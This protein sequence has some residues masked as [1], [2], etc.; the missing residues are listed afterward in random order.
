MRYMRL[1]LCALAAG[2]LSCQDD[3]SMGPSVPDDLV[4]RLEVSP[5]QGNLTAVGANQQ[6]SAV[7]RNAAGLALSG[8]SILWSS[9]N[10][11]VATIDP[12]TGL[13][14]AVANG[15]TEISARVGNVTGT[16]Q[17]T[18]AQIAATIGVTPATATITSLGGS[19]Q[20]SATPRDQNGQPISNLAVQWSSST[21][22]V[23]AVDPTTGLVTA[24]SNGTTEIS[25]RTGNVTGTAQ[26]TVAQVAATI[27]VT[28]ATATITSL[29]GS[30][31]FSATPLDG[32]GQPI[33]NLTVQWSSS[34]PAVATVDP[35]TGRATAVANG[36]TTI[37]V[38]APGGAVTGT[39]T[40]TVTQVAT[41]LA[42]V[43]EPGGVTV[44]QP[45]V[46]APVLEV[47]DAN[48]N[49]VAG[50][51]GR[52]VSASA[53]LQAPAGR[54]VGSASGSLTPG[55]TT[56]ATTISGR[57]A[58]T[59]LRVEGLAGN[60]VLNFSAAALTSAVSRVFALTPGP[61]SELLVVM[62]DNVDVIAQTV[63]D[64]QVAVEDAYG[65]RLSS[66]TVNWTILAGGGTLSASSS[67]SD[68][69]GLASIA[70]TTGS[71]TG[72]ENRVRATLGTTSVTRDLVARTHAPIGP[73]RFLRDAD[74][75]S[76]NRGASLTVVDALGRQVPTP[77]ITWSVTEPYGCCEVGLLVVANGV[78][79]QTR[80]P[81]AFGYPFLLLASISGQPVNGRLMI[82]AH[83][84]VADRIVIA[85]NHWR[86]MVPTE[87][88]GTVESAVP[89]F[90]SG[91]DVG[92]QAQYELMGATAE[93]A[94]NATFPASPLLA[95]STA[96]EDPAVCGSSSV[97]LSFGRGCFLF[98]G[99]PQAAHPH[100]DII[101]HEMGHQT[102]NAIGRSMFPDIYTRGF[103]GHTWGEGDATLF[104]MWSLQRIAGDAALSSSVRQSAG[105]TLGD[106]RASYEN[107]LLGWEASTTPFSDSNDGAGFNAS[108]WDGIVGRLV[109]E[110]GW[111]WIR[112]YTR[113]YRNDPVVRQLL[114]LDGAGTTTATR[115]T[116]AAAAV[117]A[118]I[119]V[120]LR[121]RFRAWRFPVDDALFQALFNH[122]MV[123][124][125]VPYNPL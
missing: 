45:L 117:S 2:T 17:L 31:Q 98:L 114:Q 40:L 44:G 76:P 105:R 77:M 56:T 14:T 55:L 90:T 74:W 100:W 93:L 53:T 99:G 4:A 24:V 46:P 61:P 67:P 91:L 42:V 10:L 7:A 3:K 62:G 59:D 120:D 109:D 72:V 52:V 54:S 106:I 18:V 104:G 81:V 103:Q 30:Q 60:Y 101:F 6:F 38:A 5:S 112:R 50:D 8:K 118:A 97:P 19:Q 107:S 80:A 116:F 36:T 121:S 48:G 29:G 124:M 33:S 12:A 73:Y 78:A 102:T 65:N 119:S 13:A 11:S 32:N 64:A 71:V 63:V 9:S 82:L 84:T 66:V 87:W 58:F 68:T 27:G 34:A 37:S 69:R 15:T 21:P 92:W 108:V 88:N 20:F 96:R 22:A 57:A 83:R 95:A 111:E 49:R 89:G 125:Q 110:Y 39:A 51:N 123:A 28:P 26:L 79:S 113:S 41:H 86:L 1:M 47:R 35:A 75:T 115:A 70:W 25:A 122:L 85:T 94:F 43:T 16:A 23:A